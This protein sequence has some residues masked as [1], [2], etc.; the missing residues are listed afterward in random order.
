MPLHWN[1]DAYSIHFD[2]IHLRGWT[3]HLPAPI[4][5]VEA[6]F[7]P[8]IGTVVLSSYG[9][10]PSHDL[11]SLLGPSAAA[12]RFD[13]WLTVP[14]AMLNSDF[15]LTFNLADGERLCTGL[16]HQV[17]AFHDPFHACWR[18]FLEMLYAMPPGVVLEIGSRARSAITRK[19]V[20]GHHDYV[21][22]DILPGP[23]VD[24]LGDAHELAQ[25]F[26]RGQFVAAFSFSVFEHLVMPWKVALELN[27]VLQQ[28]GLVFT[29]THQ[30]WPM[31]EEPWDFWRFSRHSWQALFNSDTGYEIIETA[32]GDYA[33]IYPC[34]PNTITRDL[35]QQSAYLGSACIARKVS[36]TTLT[37]PVPTHVAARDMY[38]KGELA[39][40][41]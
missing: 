9:Q 19:D 35:P 11:V 21:G 28:G 26:T 4:T 17:A 23:N 32:E 2:R 39:A 12:C 24:I 31:H 10:V 38:P 33:E 1:V 34:R 40:P 29:Q 36:E 41:P 7:P 15:S 30:T 22:I 16:V 20:V 14:R 3:H 6:V 18:R 27:S 5:S 8:P 37:W 13:E 25:R